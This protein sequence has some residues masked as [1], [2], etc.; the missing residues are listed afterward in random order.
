MN[1]GIVKN[2]AVIRLKYLI[3]KSINITPIQAPTFNI[4]PIMLI[5]VPLAFKMFR[6]ISSALEFHPIVT[7]RAKP[8]REAKF[9][10]KFLTKINIL[11]QICTLKSYINSESESIQI[12]S[13][14]IHTNIFKCE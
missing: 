3:K 9:L 11:L 7:P 8:P 12:Y 2:M 5:S 10:N 14:M 4:P 6:R 1:I 13:N